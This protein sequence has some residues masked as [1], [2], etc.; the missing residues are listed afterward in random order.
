MEIIQELSLEEEFTFMIYNCPV[1]IQPMD[2]SRKPITSNVW[3]EGSNDN[4]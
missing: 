3:R 2:S 4:R 1:E